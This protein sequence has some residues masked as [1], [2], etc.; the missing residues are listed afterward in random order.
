MNNTSLYISITSLCLAIFALGWNFYRDV[1]LKPRVKGS[2]QIS[3]IFHGEGKLGPFL[4]IC[5]VNHGPGQ[6]VL[7]S[8][9]IAQK[10]ML[11][12]L[13]PTLSGFF[14]K[15]TKWAHV[16]HD[17]IN[18]YSGK[19]PHKLEVGEKID[20]FFTSEKEA[21]LSIDPTHVGIRDSFGRYHCVN[22][23]Q[24]N[25]TKKEF[26]QDFPRRPWGSE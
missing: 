9:Y 6:V 10:S 17:Y 3:H 5:F 1:L 19:L 14:K 25:L 18:P 12:F 8:I 15:Q 4:S 26:F 16:M 20:L 23:K 21:F 2:I 11:R 7:E 24:L 22:K 13:G